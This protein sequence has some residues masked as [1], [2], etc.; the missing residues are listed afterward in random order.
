[1]LS[2]KRRADP[3]PMGAISTRDAKLTS[4]LIPPQGMPEGLGS[5]RLP[6]S[7]AL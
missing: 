3:R 2:L 6:R 4:Q 1:M 5:L 7:Y